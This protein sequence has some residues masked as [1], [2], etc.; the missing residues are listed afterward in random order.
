MTTA[1]TVTLDEYERQIVLRYK[2]A[3]GVEEILE[4]APPGECTIEVDP[5]HL[6]WMAQDLCH[7]IVR[8]KVPDRLLD[9]VDALCT[10]LEQL[11]GS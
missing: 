5:V 1:V 4:S 8:G 2:C 7:A 3:Y 6:Q 9:E 11:G 10:R